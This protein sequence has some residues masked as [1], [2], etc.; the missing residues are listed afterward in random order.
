MD[1]ID[2]RIIWKN[3]SDLKLILTINNFIEKHGIIST[4]QYQKS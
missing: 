2:G 1:K 4:R 3:Q